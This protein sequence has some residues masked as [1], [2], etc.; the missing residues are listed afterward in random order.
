MFLGSCSGYSRQAMDFLSLKWPSWT[1]RVNLWYNP[2]P[3]HLCST[4]L[5]FWPLPKKVKYHI[6]ITESAEISYYK[7]RAQSKK[8]KQSPFLFLC[9]Y[10]LTFSSLYSVYSLVYRFNSSAFSSSALGNAI[11]FNFWDTKQQ[12]WELTILWSI[13]WT[14]N[15]Q[16]IK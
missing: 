11:S 10:I 7:A 16:L 13:N 6:K 1:S 3:K 12:N 8:P 9:C 5:S 2:Q 15:F 4:S 14:I